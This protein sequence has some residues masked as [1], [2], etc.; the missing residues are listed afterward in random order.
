VA[1]GATAPER[2]AAIRTGGAVDSLA[3]S[4]FARGA[5]TDAIAAVRRLTNR[6][7]NAGMRD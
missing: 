4:S 3:A 1:A 6:P 7:L 2:V 5:I